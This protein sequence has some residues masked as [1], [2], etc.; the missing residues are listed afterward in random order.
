MVP[1]R[2]LVRGDPSPAT[3]TGVAGSIYIVKQGPHGIVATHPERLELP[4][5]VAP[6]VKEALGSAFNTLRPGLLTIG[7]MR[8][9]DTGFAFDSSFIQPEA[10]KAFVD[11]ADL[12]LFLQGRDLKKRL[13]PCSVF[14]HADPTGTDDYNKQLSARRARS[15]YAVLIREPEIWHELYDTPL[16][17]DD[18]HWKSVQQCLSVG[19]RPPDNL[20]EPPFYT[21]EIDGGLTPQTRSETE[22]A[23]GA[24]RQARFGKSSKHLTRDER[25][26]LFGEYMDVLCH[27]TAAGTPTPDDKFQLDPKKDFLAR[28][29]GKL[30]KGDIQGCSEFNPVFLLNQDQL[31]EDNKTKDG[32]E[33]RN[34]AYVSDR[35]VVVYIFR[36]GTQ[37]DP[38][39]WPCPDFK[40]DSKKCEKRFWS[41][42]IARRKP[43]Q[44]EDRT[45]GEKMRILS[46]DGGGV[47]AVEPVENTG[48]TMACRFYHGL[49]VRSPCEAKLKEWV[50]RF[51]VDHI[52]EKHPKARLLFLTGRRYVVHLG[53]SEDAP[54]IRGT[55]GKRGEIR[56]PVL[57]EQARF[58][59]KIDAYGEAE[60]PDD[61]DKPAPPEPGPSSSDK[62]AEA[63]FDSDRF[64]DEDLF[65]SYLL[66]GGVLNSFDP[67]DDLS[68]KQ[69]LYNLGFGETDPATWS[70]DD[71]DA[72]MQG[73][74]DRRDMQDA[75][76]DDVKQ[77]VHDDHEAADPPEAVGADGPPGAAAS[78]G[79][80]NGA[81]GGDGSEAA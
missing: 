70:Q 65:H 38:D 62:P 78:N 30:L 67:S 54:V 18:W 12:M 55:L 40:A 13:A 35:R 9:F 57:D 29:A 16:G 8:I 3:G 77:A 4:G 58:L 7:C 43:A 50:V 14:G 27:K 21:G 22:D 2:R 28:G 69:R 10:E 32:Q 74:R 6:I 71:F 20:E 81:S 41:D 45:F 1:P 37:V 36:H 72:A 24:Y 80:A 64:P 51:L 63:G 42:H 61:P 19:L 15:V 39:A 68:V 5:L 59:I 79:A 60:T 47:I 25:K 11:F 76:D 52:D 17:H 26:I 31:D 75:S 49:A 33:E 73:F 53:E 44:S 34:S 66:D 48:N 23:V 46:I 56:I